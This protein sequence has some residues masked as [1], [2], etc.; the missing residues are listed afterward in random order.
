MAVMP[1][2]LTIVLILVVVLVLDVARRALTG[3]KELKSHAKTQRKQ[4]NL[5]WS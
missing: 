5:N 3:K 4:K 1:K 2:A